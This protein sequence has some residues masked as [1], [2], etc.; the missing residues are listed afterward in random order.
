M[1]RT[2]P[3][4]SSCAIDRIGRHIGEDGGL[5]EPAVTR[6][7]FAAEQEPAFRLANGDVAEN[8]PERRLID[9]G[10]H[11][12]PGIVWVAH[13]HDF[14]RLLHNL[15][16]DF[17]IHIRDDDGPRAGRAL[18]ALVP[19]SRNDN[20]RGGCVQVCRLV[21]HDGVFAPHLQQGP[22][23]PNLA[24]LHLGGALVD[25]DADLHGAGECDEPRLGVIHQHIADPA[26]R[27]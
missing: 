15:L 11:V 2:G 20:A 9:H 25:A 27:P 1:D 4:I 3:K 22:L 23:Q 21:Y 19:K 24:G 5:D 6:H 12:V 17:I 18:L 10:A 26:A 13:A 14:P 7:G 8:L 16:D